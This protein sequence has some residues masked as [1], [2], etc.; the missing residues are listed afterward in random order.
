MSK[1]VSTPE[2]R[3]LLSLHL[4]GQLAYSPKLQSIVDSLERRGYVSV[5]DK[6]VRITSAGR[7]WLDADHQRWMAQA[8][9]V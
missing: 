6:Q 7:A 8:F 1:P 5:I 3:Q 9:A 4:A 2:R